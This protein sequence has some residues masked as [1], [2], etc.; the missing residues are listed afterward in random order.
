MDEGIKTVIPVRGTR[1]ALVPPR[2][3]QEPAQVIEQ[4]V[5]HLRERVPDGVELRVDW[6]L[7]GC[8]PF[9]ASTNHPAVRAA[10]EALSRRMDARP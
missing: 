5:A 3:D 1:Q 6:T 9:I 4:V 2:P 8:P 7:A 10:R